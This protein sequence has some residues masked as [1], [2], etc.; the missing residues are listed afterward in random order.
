VTD[1]G[2]GDEPVVYVEPAGTYRSAW[3]M[4]S[5][6]I[7][8]FTI[9]C[10]RAG[11][12]VHLI[13]W[14]LAGLAIVGVNVLVVY[15]ARTLR[16]ITVTASEIR[17]GE[18]QVARADIAATE[19]HPERATHVLGQTPHTPLPRGIR[20]LALRL[21]DGTLVAVA[22]RQPDRLAAVLGVSEL[23]VAVSVRAATDDDYLALADID[24]RAA[25]L[26]RVAE[27]PV[28]EPVTEAQ[29]RAASIVL[30]ADDPPA[31]F[32]A[33][34]RHGGQLRILALAVLPA[35]MRAGVGTALVNA[36]GEWARQHGCAGLTVT[37]A[38]P[39]PW[40]T[41]FFATTIVKTSAQ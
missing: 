7:V 17:V 3:L 13:G 2:P 24:E 22:T 5:F 31:G 23:S 9:D 33:A 40:Q 21:V 25:A 8:G 6:V 1:S 26:F 30:V 27:L 38:E 20:G 41:A 4:A 18:Q 10:V 29:L 37:I 32:V 34:E 15:A 35:R 39:A 19:D 12:V 36:L 16:S 14:G 11:R 28:P